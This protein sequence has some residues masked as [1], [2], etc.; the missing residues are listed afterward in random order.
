[1]I[2]TSVQHTVKMQPPSRTRAV[3]QGAGWVQQ[4]GYE[5]YLIT[6]YQLLCLLLPLLLCLLPSW[7][8]SLPPFLPLSL[9]SPEL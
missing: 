9:L 7:S 8:L 5:N 1:M 2:Q 3:H 6:E 4:K